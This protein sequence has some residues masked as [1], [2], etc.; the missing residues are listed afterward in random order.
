[1]KL[2]LFFSSDIKENLELSHLKFSA[3]NVADI[4]LVI[5]RQSYQVMQ[6]EFF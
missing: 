1:M 3:K 6:K 4:F 5:T 2:F